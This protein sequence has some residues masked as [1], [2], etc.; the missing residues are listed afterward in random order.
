MLKAVVL[1][2]LLLAL[3]ITIDS[4][5]KVID[6]IPGTI[7]RWNVIIFTLG[8]ITITWIFYNFITAIIVMLLTT[9]IK[10]V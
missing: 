3:K 5:E 6:K 10:M 8:Q 7:I 2:L 1:I 9:K 4:N